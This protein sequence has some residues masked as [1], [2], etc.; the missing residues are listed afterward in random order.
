MRLTGASG[1]VSRTVQTDLE[2]C[3]RE[4]RKLDAAAR[5]VGA[6]ARYDL[7][8]RQAVEAVRN[9]AAAGILTPMRHVRLI[10]ILAGSDAAESLY[11]GGA[12][13]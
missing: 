12:A 2:A 10:E 3:A 5:N 9:A 1:P 11:S 7:L 4:I 13:G 8:L 6:P